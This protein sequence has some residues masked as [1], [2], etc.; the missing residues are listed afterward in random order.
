MLNERRKTIVVSASVIGNFII[1]YDLIVYQF[2]L[3]EISEHCFG[4]NYNIY[5]ISVW[6]QIIYL[7]GFLSRPVTA[8]ILGAIADIRGRA[9]I[10]QISVFISSIGAVGMSM[11]PS[12][13]QIGVLSG[14]LLLICR[15]L[16]SAGGAGHSTAL[17]FLVEHTSVF[18]RGKTI[19]YAVTT[20]IAALLIATA[21]VISYRVVVPSPDLNNYWKLI[22][23]FTIPFMLLAKKCVFEPLEFILENNYDVKRPLSSFLINLALSELPKNKNLF[24]PS[25]F[26]ILLGNFSFAMAFEYIPRM[27]AKEFGVD[28]LQQDVIMMIIFA[29]IIPLTLYL[30]AKSDKTGR[31]VAIRKYVLL[32]T[33][34]W[35]PFFYFLADYFILAS[36]LGGVIMFSACGYFVC[37]SVLLIESIS[38]SRARCTIHVLICIVP[39]SVF[40]GFLPMILEKLPNIHNGHLI[41][42]I[43]LTIAS[44]L[45]F[46]TVKRI[47]EPLDKC[48]DIAEYSLDNLQI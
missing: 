47:P 37:G 23:L 9:F 44:L 3:F 17:A 36:I 41:L 8:L 24:I 22:F 30:G 4:V 21:I 20:D 42:S 43:F 10:L 5:N 29:C 27:L 12:Y 28:V 16:I 34:L 14:V 45:V 11:M 39:S 1:T 2:L 15:I 33:F 31:I 18:N 38:S 19:S 6:V 7:L 48:K 25:I 40:L 35:V 32:M 26:C 46:F 13:E